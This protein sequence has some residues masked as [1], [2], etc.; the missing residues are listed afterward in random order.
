MPILFLNFDRENRLQFHRK[1]PIGSPETQIMQMEGPVAEI[2]LY[3][4]STA[5]EAFATHSTHE[6]LI[7]SDEQEEVCLHVVPVVD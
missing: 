1:P 2:M 5:G 7:W 4:H 6:M 3:G